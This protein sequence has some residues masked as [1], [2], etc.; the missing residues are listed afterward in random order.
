MSS[1][2]AAGAHWPVTA[3][4]PMTPAAL[5]MSKPW[6]LDLYCCAGGAA[7]GYQR[8]GFRV[9]GVDK[10][11]RPNYCGDEFIYGD[12]LTVLREFWDQRTLGYARRVMMVHASPPCQHDNTLTR[13][14]NASRGWGA[15][16]EQLVPPTRRLLDR[17]GIPYVIEQPS[18][19]TMIRKDLTLCT[20]MFDTG[21]APWVQRHRDFEISGFAVPQPVHPKGPV[22]GHRGYVRG[23]R[24]RHGDTPG[25]FRDGPYVAAY[26][27]G[28]GK[29]TV[30]EMQHALGIDWTD[31]REELTEALP[32]WYT[33]HIGRAFLAGR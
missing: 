24:G 28:G 33:E 25:F 20:D 18:G 13:G 4:A 12:A 10:V 3:C 21:P 16:H 8:A 6:V 2:L 7:R 26:G 9:V 1:V 27:D 23:Y 5:T 19:G 14:T 32:I 31:V 22:A 15:E 11:P 17:I 30:A 29:A